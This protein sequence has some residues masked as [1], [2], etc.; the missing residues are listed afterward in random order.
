[1]ERKTTFYVERE[2]THTKKGGLS[3]EIQNKE[4]RERIIPTEREN[5]MWAQH[6]GEYIK[7]RHEEKLRS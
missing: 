7:K 5:N 3:S 4:E 2:E 1:V 6:K